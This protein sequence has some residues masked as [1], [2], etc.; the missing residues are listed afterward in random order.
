MNGRRIL[1]VD[2]ENTAR[3]LISEILTDEGYVPLTAGDGR[4]AL[5]AVKH[6]SPD[7]VLLDLKLP[8][9]DGLEVLA[10]IRTTHPHL[11]V[12]LVSAHGD[13]SSAVRAV[14]LGAYDFLEKPLDADRLVVTV[15][16]ALWSVELRGEVA[17]LK[18]AIGERYRMVGSSSVM[19]GLREHILQAASSKAHV[20]ILGETGSGKD[21]V[22]RAI[23]NQS[24]RAKGPFVKLN[25]AAIPQELV[26]SELFGYKKGAFTGAHANKPGRIEAA[27]GGTIFFDEI[28]EMNLAAQAKLL[29]FLESFAIERLGETRCRKVNVRVIAATNKKIEDE[30]KAKRFR[31]D[32]YYRLNVIDIHVPPLRT[33]REDIPELVEYFLEITCQELGIPAKTLEKSALKK[34]MELSWPGNV[35]ELRNTIEKAVSA[36]SGLVIRLGDLPESVDECDES[37]E[38]ESIS[39]HDARR[40]FERRCI[41]QALEAEDWNMSAAAERLGLDRTN[42]YRKIKA[43]KIERKNH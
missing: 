38:P 7:L 6:Q 23:H 29:S 22:A 35:R 9:I 4:E 17:R 28:G 33:H 2:D 43:L 15:R 25:C 21:L 8:D 37:L 41:L 5:D 40:E 24:D 26:E 14:K 13:V 1:I 16:N 19:R 10:G 39:L 11:P 34:L 18:E 12:I 20:F 27:D 30:V 36:S 31:E 3:V 32:L 42:L